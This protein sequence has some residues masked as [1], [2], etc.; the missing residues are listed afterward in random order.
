VADVVHKSEVR[1]KDNVSTNTKADEKLRKLRV[2]VVEMD[3]NRDGQPDKPKVRHEKGY[4]PN[5]IA[6]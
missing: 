4:Y 2:E 6:R 1:R 3:V 5:A